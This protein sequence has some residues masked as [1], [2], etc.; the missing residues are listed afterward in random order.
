MWATN[1]H[2][3]RSEVHLCINIRSHSRS[4][5]LRHTMMTLRMKESLLLFFVKTG[6]Y[7]FNLQFNH[8]RMNEMVLEMSNSNQ[9]F[10]V[11]N[12]KSEMQAFQKGPI[13]GVS[14]E[15]ISRDVVW[16]RILPLWPPSKKNIKKDNIF[17]RRF[18]Q[19]FALFPFFSCESPANAFPSNKLE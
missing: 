15:R 11:L 16:P 17:L 1:I 2:N 8:W 3:S 4:D 6:Y 12:D 9:P 18:S 7:T 19:L 10:V 5:S 13:W 14:E